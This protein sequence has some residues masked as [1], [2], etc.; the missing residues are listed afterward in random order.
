VE[1]RRLVDSGEIEEA[2]VVEALNAMGYEE[3]AQHVYGMHYKEWKDRHQ[4]EPTEEKMQAYQASIKIHAK[5][6]KALLE[7][8]ANS[9]DVTKPK[10][11]A[12]AETAAADTTTTAGATSSA[13][14][15]LLSN[16]CCQDVPEPTVSPAK[17]SRN[18][19]PFQPPPIP[20]TYHRP[21][22][23]AI[24]TISDRASA[25]AYATGDL[26]GPAVQKAVT[27]IMGGAA[28]VTAVV[29]DDSAIIQAKLKTWCD[30]M[31]AAVDLILTTG[32]TGLSPRDVTPEATRDILDHELASLM[33]FCVTESSHL[34]PLA[35]LSR[36][37][38]GIR[39]S[40][41]IANLPGN[42]KGVA[43]LVPLLLPLLLHAVADLQ[44][45]VRPEVLAIE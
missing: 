12:N 21:P 44:E 30:D 1:A 6:D 38:A 32:G 33:A 26:S 23:L 19:G 7:P 36:G 15:D 40:T 20:T 3:A 27:Q 29:P 22:T 42:P 39:K 17:M 45:P 28:M 24:L 13:P 41:V 18:V 16:V 14:S 9:G 8:R 2:E 43:E 31:D 37:T 5:H 4:Q 10:T 25:G 34:Q 35:S 11:A